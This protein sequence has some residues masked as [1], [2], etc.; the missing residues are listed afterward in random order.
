VESALKT[1]QDV[2]FLKIL[3]VSAVLIGTVFMESSDIKA[4]VEEIM[5]W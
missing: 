5:G 2:M 4:T 1:H 3:G